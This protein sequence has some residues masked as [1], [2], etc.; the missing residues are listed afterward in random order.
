MRGHVEIVRLLLEH[1]A[2]RSIRNKQD[3]VGSSLVCRSLPPPLHTCKPEFTTAEGTANIGRLESCHMQRGGNLVCS[4]ATHPLPTSARIYV[5]QV[6]VDLA[7][8]CW[9]HSYRFTREVFAN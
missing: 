4:A 5:F 3:K 9:S 2:D 1:G 8:P 7:Q 6:A